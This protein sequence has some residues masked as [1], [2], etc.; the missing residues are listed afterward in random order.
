MGC[1][2]W[3]TV[4][5]QLSFYNVAYKTTHRWNWDVVLKDL[6]G[7]LSGLSNGVIVSRNNITKNSPKCSNTNSFLNGI[8]CSNTSTWIRFAWNNFNPGQ[9][10]L[11]NITNPQGQMITSPMLAKRLTHPKGFMVALEAQNEYNFIIDLASNPVNITY[12][13]TFYGFIPGD[14]I[15]IKHKLYME[16]DQVQLFGSNANKCYSPLSYSSNA[17]GDWYWD[18]NTSTLSYILMN[19]ATLP[20]LDYPV[21]F[22]AIKC[23]YVGCQPPQNPSYKLPVTSRPASALFWS[24]VSSWSFALPGYGGYLGNNK[25]GLPK[26]NDTVLIP[27]GKYLVCDIENLPRLK[28]LQ[29]EGILEFD[30]RMDHYLEVDMILINGGQLIIGWE[31][32][33]ILTNVTI[34]LTG[35]KDSLNFR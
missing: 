22:S 34:V 18:N 2:G 12:T 8:A 1:G 4:T 7:S 21:T 24:N 33:P 30:N 29:I 32:D 10:I 9:A 28:T 31:N 20:F 25:F 23:Y 14:Y 17:N 19:T 5:N 13:G 16:P 11:I 3:T 15:I 27:E 6:D 26:D 35:D